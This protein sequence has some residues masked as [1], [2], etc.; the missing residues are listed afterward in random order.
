MCPKLNNAMTHE[1]QHAIYEQIGQRVR[2]ARDAARLTQGELGE[3]IG[4]TRASVT[5]IETARQ[6]VQLHTL[7]AIAHALE[8]PVAALLPS[9]ETAPRAASPRVQH[10]I[11]NL[12]DLKPSERQ[13]LEEMLSNAV[14]ISTFVQRPG[15][16]TR[17]KKSP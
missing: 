10:A 2:D 4:L 17:A 14:P 1:Q 3:R 5:N 12:K 15:R 8:V 16:V 11:K 7:Y 13:I 6:N 9:L